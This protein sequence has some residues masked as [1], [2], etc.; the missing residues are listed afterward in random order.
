MRNCRFGCLY[1]IYAIYTGSPH[2]YWL[3][4]S[5]NL[6]SSWGSEKPENRVS[7]V[8]GRPTLMYT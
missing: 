4:C 1:E 7:L 5:K 2:K 8:T 6:S 3:V